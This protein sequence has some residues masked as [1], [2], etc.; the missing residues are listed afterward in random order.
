MVLGTRS[1]NLISGVIKIFASQRLAERELGI[2]NSSI[3]KVLRGKIKQ[4]HG[5]Y[6]EYMS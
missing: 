6:F 1:T 5:Y 3:R 4:S 2:P